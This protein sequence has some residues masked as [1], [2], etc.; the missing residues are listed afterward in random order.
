M[1]RLTMQ[2]GAMMDGDD[3]SDSDYDEQ[4]ESNRMNGRGNTNAPPDMLFGVV[5]IAPQQRKVFMVVCVV[6]ALA[7]AF[8]VA[9][10]G[11]SFQDSRKADGATG[12][13]YNT[14]SEHNIHSQPNLSNGGMLRASAYEGEANTAPEG[15]GVRFD[16]EGAPP[17]SSG[18]GEGMS[19]HFE[20]SN[21]APSHES[22]VGGD[23]GAYQQYASTGDAQNQQGS[24]TG[25]TA[26]GGAQT[27]QFGQVLLSQTEL[28]KEMQDQMK[29]QQEMFMKMQEMQQQQPQQQLPTQQQPLPAAPYEAPA[30]TESAVMPEAAAVPLPPPLTPEEAPPSVEVPVPVE[31]TAPPP[32]VEGPNVDGFRDAWDLPVN[33]ATDTPVFWHIPKVSDAFYLFA[34]EEYTH[35]FLVTDQRIRCLYFPFL[36]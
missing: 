21:E 18:N 34:A 5:H 32:I 10:V 25:V 4:M 17:R 22:D 23:A 31:A 1:Q 13:N 12:G 6:M 15:Q 35:T 24:F 8:N 33:P 29:Q 27:D 20:Y 11:Y 30:S 7:T 19:T 9:T 28:M 2:S 16:E 3:D 14:L 36:I 26:D